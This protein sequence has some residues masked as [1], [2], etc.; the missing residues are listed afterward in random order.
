MDDNVIFALPFALFV[1]YAV[2]FFIKRNHRK[3]SNL[4]YYCGVKLNKE[5]AEFVDIATSLEV[6]K[7]KTC[8]KC[9]EE[10][11]KPSKLK[12]VFNILF[13]IIAMLSLAY[14]RGFWGS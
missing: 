9:A 7:H 4:C 2:Y 3:Y 1:I 11:I 6:E 13:F 10:P 14:I 5:N 12:L 8:L